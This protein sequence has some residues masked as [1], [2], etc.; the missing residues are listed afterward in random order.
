MEYRCFTVSFDEETL[1]LWL[2]I[3][4]ILEEL[5]LSLKQVAAEFYRYACL[6]G[7]DSEI[8]G[9]GASLVRLLPAAG[10][11]GS[12][13]WCTPYARQGLNFYADFEDVSRGGKNGG[14]FQIKSF[15]SFTRDQNSS[16]YPFSGKIQD[17]LRQNPDRNAVLTGPDFMG[18]REGI[19]RFYRQRLEDFPPLLVR[20]GSGGTGVACLWDTLTGPI[21]SVAAEKNGG[22]LSELDA[23][24][25]FLA[26]ERLGNEFSPYILEKADRFF[27]LLLEIYSAAAKDRGLAA[28][29]VLED[30]HLANPKA[31]NIVAAACHDLGRQYTIYIYGTCSSGAAYGAY[32]EPLFHQVFPFTPDDFPA[33]HPPELPEDLW[34]I[35]YAAFLFRRFFPGPLLA[36]LL[37]EEGENPVMVSRALDILLSL[38]IIDCTAD[39]LPRIY[40]FQYLAEIHLGSRKEKIRAMVRNRLLDWVA[41]GKFRYCFNL[42]RILAELGALETPGQSPGVSPELILDTFKA[43]LANGTY[44]DLQKAIDES[45]L[46]L[47]VAE[48]EH[49]PVLLSIFRTLGSLFHG[50]EEEIRRCFADPPPEC[51]VPVYKVQTGLDRAAFC[52]GIH[53]TKTASALAKGIMVDYHN[54]PA[55]KGLSRAYRLFALTNL[56]GKRLSEAL[57]YFSFAVEKAEKSEDFDELGIAAYYT[58][59]GH[60]LHGNIAR[61]ERLALQSERAACRAGRVS[62]ADKAR[63]LR[64]KLRFESGRYRD[65]L[66]LFEGL[67]NNPM[68]ILSA[69]AEQVLD[70]WIY[71]SRIYQNDRDAA[72]SGGT[73]RDI[74]LFEVEAAYLG[75]DYQR[76]LDLADRFLAGLPVRSQDIPDRSLS[77][78][79]LFLFI[80]QPDWRSGFSQCELYVLPPK[81]FWGPL[82]SAYRNLALCRAGQPGTAFGEEARQNM[83]R[84]IQDERFSEMN[85]N[86]AFFF[87]AWYRVLEESGAEGVDMNTAVS[88]AF[89]RLQ[90][91]ASRI[92]D[93]DT[94]R[95]FL[96]LHYWNNALCETAKKHKLI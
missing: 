44:G 13:I 65:A 1:G 26:R 84:I 58:A 21:R 20:F 48:P 4:L 92:D 60:F 54:S 47:I 62:W 18:K 95:S 79:E 16:Y 83:Q 32:W 73:C 82:I 15:H 66:E 49:I 36:D 35:T 50:T 46:D 55:E 6:L 70:A 81:D 25:G 72:V 27:R 86:N 22:V 37:K 93:P 90:R 67:R 14:F 19:F 56:S 64:G 74:L 41:A 88:V 30:L 31:G 7:R 76:A 38:G 11:T 78:P 77:G 85:P 42:L 61:A 29:L 43:D 57:D 75:G 33:L 12:G 2:N 71:R 5:Q 87:Y 53:D 94:W 3:V 45:R 8:G 52:L 59:G 68:G 40:D 51:T 69:D 39:P 28:I 17:T 91:R 9:N 89:K 96:N 24:G 34:A 63:F 23:L 80:E 10:L